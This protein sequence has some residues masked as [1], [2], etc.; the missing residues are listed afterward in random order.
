MKVIREH[1]LKIAKSKVVKH[2]Y[3]TLISK[4]LNVPLIDVENELNEL[5]KEGLIE[6]RYILLCHN[7]HCLRTLDEQSNIADF[8][9]EYDCT[10]CGE[11]MEE[12]ESG[13]IQT[14]Y[15]GIK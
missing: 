5:I 14:V 6:K 2:F 10:Y 8:K 3:P 9:E 15:T 7:D 11:E 12:I 4:R 1:I 13:Y